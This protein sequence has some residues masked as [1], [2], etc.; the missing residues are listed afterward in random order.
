MSEICTYP[1]LLT[2]ICPRAACAIGTMYC[3]YCGNVSAAQ[4]TAK[5]YVCV[6]G[7]SAG[8]CTYDGKTVLSPCRSQTPSA[9]SVGSCYTSVKVA[10]NLHVLLQETKDVVTVNAGACPTTP[11]C[12]YGPA[13][14][15][16]FCV[17]CSPSGNTPLACVADSGQPCWVAYQVNVFGCGC[18]TSTPTCMLYTGIRVRA[19]SVID[20]YDVASAN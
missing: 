4:P 13:T 8:S 18:V 11:R 5:P 12:G 17:H 3:M 2:R 10:S 15:S 16:R 7:L 19:A 20:S 14:G 1:C 9:T 6:A